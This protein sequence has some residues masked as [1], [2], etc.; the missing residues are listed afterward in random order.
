MQ[1]P[2]NPY[3]Q[4]QWQQPQ[5]QCHPQQPSFQ[6]QQY[7][8][9][10]QY[11]PS[12]PYT[13][14]PKR[15]SGF[16]QWFRTRS[17]KTK[18]GIG[19]G[20]IIAALLL[21][22]CAASVY[23]SATVATTLTPTPSTGHA[24]ILNSPTRNI[25]TETPTLSP[26]PTQKPTPVPTQA[27]TTITK[28]PVHPDSSIQDAA[29]GWSHGVANS[30]VNNGIVWVTDVGAWNANPNDY[31]WGVP[32]IQMDCF[33]IQQAIWYGL[34]S[35]TNADGSTTVIKSDFKEVDITFLTTFLK[36]AKSFASCRLTSPMSIRLT[37]RVCGLMV[38]LLVPGPCMTV[39]P[40]SE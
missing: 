5:Q 20:T 37:K 28:V 33:N 6:Q 24:A 31:T 16:R 22:I 13:V 4:Q 30:G 27:P 11:P 8:Q 38:T 18:L 32:T 29:Q 10:S 34:K 36:N 3:P 2:P 1:Q 7:Q 40:Y 23:G 9:P 12:P 25:P 15:P 21:C 14:L 17:R 19:C 35:T 26:T 39:H